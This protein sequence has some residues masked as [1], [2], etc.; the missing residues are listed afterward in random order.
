MSADLFLGGMAVLTL[1]AIVIVAL[2][3]GETK[4]HS[5]EVKQNGDGNSQR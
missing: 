4:S 2:T 5:F 3:S 1:A